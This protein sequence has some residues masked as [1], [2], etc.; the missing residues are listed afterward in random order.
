MA[1]SAI[2]GVPISS[3]QNASVKDVINLAGERVEQAFPGEP[4]IQAQLYATLA[5]AHRGL[6]NWDE[7]LSLSEK[8]L[9]IL[10]NVYEQS[11]VQATARMA[12]ALIQF[13]APDGDLQKVRSSLIEADQFAARSPG[14]PSKLH[15][16]VLLILG[17][18]EPDG[19]GMERVM[20]AAGEEW[21]EAGGNPTDDFLATVHYK[22]GQIRVGQGRFEEADVELQQAIDILDGDG[23]KTSIELGFA[24]ETLGVSKTRRGEYALARDQLT[25]ALNILEQSAVRNPWLVVTYSYLSET[26]RLQGNLVEAQTHL[27]TAGQI[28]RS[29]ELTSQAPHWMLLANQQAELDLM[30]GEFSKVKEQL[31]VLLNQVKPS[32]MMGPHRAKSL[33]LTALAHAN[34]GEMETASLVG[35]EGYQALVNFYGQSKSAAAVRTRLEAAGIELYPLP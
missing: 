21:L 28:G 31:T 20:R 17:Q 15:A 30:R 29:L 32:A 22:L 7:A 12:H 16:K 5:Q 24:Y 26:A 19:Q 6:G 34:L 25:R 27:D 4:E 11:E 1:P 14:V 9:T 23:E 13:H 33:Y 35:S 8:A 2:S 18:T 10:G 3:G